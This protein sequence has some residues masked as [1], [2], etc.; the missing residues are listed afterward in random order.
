ME[1]SR[2]DQLRI[3]D[4][5]QPEREHRIRLMNSP[6]SAVRGLGRGAIA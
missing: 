6:A 4:L 2:S 1:A 5:V 3:P